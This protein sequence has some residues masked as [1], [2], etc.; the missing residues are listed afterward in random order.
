MKDLPDEHLASDAADG[1]LRSF[2]ELVSR[3][4]PRLYSFLRR[5]ISTDQE[6]EDLVQEAFLK[7]FRYIDRFDTD[8]KFSTWLYTIASRLAVSHF[9]TQRVRKRHVEVRSNSPD[10]EETTIRKQESQNLWESAR[11]LQEK[12]FQALWLRYSEDMNVKEI[13][14]IMKRKQSHV[15][16]LLHRGRLNLAKELGSSASSIKS[17]APATAKHKYSFL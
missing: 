9:R 16:V 2:E 3:Y 10:P 13:A 15:R 1:S 17:G 5:R 14:K 12:Q 7:A 8:Q 11:K 4:S 6:T